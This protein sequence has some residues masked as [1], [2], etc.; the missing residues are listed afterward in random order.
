MGYAI[1]LIPKV[2]K[3]LLYAQAV[4]TV[5][6]LDEGVVTDPADADIGSI[7]GWGFCPFY[8]GVASYIDYVGA[9]RLE[10]ECDDLADKHGERYRPPALLRNLAR[11][12]A[13]LY[14]A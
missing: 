9:K 6:C 5:R 4:E 14:P 13:T 2:K 1:C 3:R 11:D 7:L 8:G 12:G 10:A